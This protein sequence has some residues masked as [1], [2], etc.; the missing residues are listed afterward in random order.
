[1]RLEFRNG[2]FE[3]VVAN[4]NEWDVDASL[5]L[6]VQDLELYHK[7]I[8]FKMKEELTIPVAQFKRTSKSAFKMGASWSILLFR[9]PL[10]F[11]TLLLSA[12][13]QWARSSSSYAPTEHECGSK[14]SESSIE[15]TMFN[16]K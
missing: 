8:I 6:K 3:L 4:L 15:L 2:F 7:T 11:F 9:C 10:G 14:A 5:K 12:S 1:M 13:Q 16:Q